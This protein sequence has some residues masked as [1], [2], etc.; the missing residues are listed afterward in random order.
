M[1]NRLAKAG[2]DLVSLSEKIDTTSATGKMI[3]RLLALL[4]EFERDLIRERARVG[5]VAAQRRGVRFGRP[6]KLRPE[7]QALARRL[8]T[9]GHAA[10]EM[11]Q[12]FGVHVATIYPMAQGREGSNP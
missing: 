11:A 4:A 5:R 9:E 1:G 2:T 7:Q 8:M 12:L 3:F 10:K 6:P